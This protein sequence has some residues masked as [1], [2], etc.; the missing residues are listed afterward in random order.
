[1]AAAGSDWVEYK[2]RDVATGQDRPD[3]LKWIKFSGADWLKD[4][5][6]FYYGRFPEP[7]AGASLKA[8]NYFQKLYFHKLGTDQQADDSSSTS[9]PTRRNGSSHATSP[10]TAS[11]WSSPC[12]RGP[13]TSTGSSSRT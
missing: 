1:M 5:T 7:A 9:G 4:G 12:R 2:V 3:L 6:G 10:K 11:T 8:P 13:T